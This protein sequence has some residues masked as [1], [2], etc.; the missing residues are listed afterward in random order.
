LRQMKLDPQIF[1]DAQV[2]ITT[3]YDVFYNRN[4]ETNNQHGSCGVGVGAT[5]ERNEGPNKLYALDL[6]YPKV[7][8]QKLGAIET[9][10]TQKK[11]QTM[12]GTAF[13]ET[14]T[15]FLQTLKDIR[16]FLNIV[17]ESS[18]FTS[19]K[20]DDLYDALIF[21]GSQGI[22]LD[23]DFGFFPN[24]T[25]A[26]VTSRNAMELIYNNTLPSPEIY[27]ITRAYQTRHGNGFL[28]N[29]HLT[30][31]INPNPQE[32]NQFNEWQGAQR[33]APLDIDL[34]NYALACDNNYSSTCRKHLVIT[35]LDQIKGELPATINGALHHFTKVEKIVQ[36]LNTNFVQVLESRSDCST[37]LNQPEVT[38]C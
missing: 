25:R 1:I 3:P 37:Y 9:Y 4:T 17:H 15:L 11:G 19:V 13:N 26:Y 18:F 6:L 23:Q 31:D 36:H 12:T 30:L 2:M 14:L 29:E 16:P 8:E 38:I 20:Y 22:L 35:C 5:V 24:V 27:Y 21:E 34:L 33:L 28:S 10:Y 32:T 7:V